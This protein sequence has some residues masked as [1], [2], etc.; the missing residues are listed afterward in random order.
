MNKHFKVL[1][2][3]IFSVFF[4]SYVKAQEVVK[5]FNGQDLSNWNFVLEKEDV[6]AEKVYSI[7][8]GVIHIIGEP[9]GYMYTKEKYSNFHLH[10]EW[11]WPGGVESNSGIFLLIESADNPFPNGVECQLKS[12]DAGD[13]VLLNGSDLAEY[14][15]PES[16]RPKFP[17][18]PKANKSSEN[19]PGKWNCAD[20]YCYDG[21]ITVY[22]NGVFQNKGTDKVKE[23]HIGLQS[24]GKDV[25]F[26]NVLL[27]PLP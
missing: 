23:G 10:A 18:V 22:I 15:V 6:P 19:V 27:T 11:K 3:A 1:L 2:L 24:E 26:R 20:I 14:K 12:G 25:Q 5:L 21:K 4:S 17:V 16:G 13:F 8:N 9:L 7:K